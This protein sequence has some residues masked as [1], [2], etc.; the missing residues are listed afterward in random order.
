MSIRRMNEAPPKPDAGI[1]QGRGPGYGT[2]T[3]TSRGPGFGSKNAG[4]DVAP[5]SP[6]KAVNLPV[7]KPQ[8]ARRVR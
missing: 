7:T 6:R 1:G 3:D 2:P 5:T 4:P 8:P